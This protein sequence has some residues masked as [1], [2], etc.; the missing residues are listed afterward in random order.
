MEWQLSLIEGNIYL[1]CH[2]YS[3]KRIG[4]VADSALAKRCNAVL[5][6]STQRVRIVVRNIMT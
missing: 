1:L 2:R 5:C 6:K 3:E 4:N